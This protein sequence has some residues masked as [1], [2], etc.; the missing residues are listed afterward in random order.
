MPNTPGVTQ[1]AGFLNSL[2][3]QGKGPAQT[4]QNLSNPET[5]PPYNGVSNKLEGVILYA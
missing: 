5:V 4:I 3:A 1:A 2:F